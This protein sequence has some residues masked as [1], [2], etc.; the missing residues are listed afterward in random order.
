M[1]HVFS[2]SLP[3]ARLGCCGEGHSVGTSRGGQRAESRPLTEAGAS[4]Q[5]CT[6]HA[7]LRMCSTAEEQL[8]AGLKE[9]RGWRDLGRPTLVRMKVGRMRRQAEPGR[10]TC[11]RMVVGRG[12][13]VDG[14]LGRTCHLH[15]MRLADIGKARACSRRPQG[16]LRAVEMQ[17][18]C[19]D[20][21]KEA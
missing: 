7:T 3:G 1:G 21:P 9:F 5:T 8:A 14:T 18:F 19:I 6:V 20:T 11:A 16:G 4:M 15:R 2:A 17:P 13:P 12:A 10:Q